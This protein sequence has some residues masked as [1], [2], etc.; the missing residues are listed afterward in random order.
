MIKRIIKIKIERISTKKNKRSWNGSDDNYMLSLL[1]IFI[2][3]Y[4]IKKET[5]NN[6]ND[7]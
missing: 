5:Q 1:T 7:N 6:Q 2:S 3:S 4:T